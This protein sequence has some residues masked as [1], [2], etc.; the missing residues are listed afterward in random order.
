MG[1]IGFFVAIDFQHPN[2]SWVFLF[3]TWERWKSL[4]ALMEQKLP[5]SLSEILMIISSGLKEFVFWA[6]QLKEIKTNTK[7]I[8]K[9]AVF[10]SF[11]SN[12]F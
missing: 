9:I 3:G 6:T 8:L 10:R 1:F 11:I 7:M 12:I 4:Q 5:I 2:F